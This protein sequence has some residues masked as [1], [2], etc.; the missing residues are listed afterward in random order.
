VFQSR[1]G[2]AE[3]V[4][5]VPT[6]GQSKAI[7]TDQSPFGI[8]CFPHFSPFRE[9]RRESSLCAG[10]PN[11]A[12][13]VV[14]GGGG[15]QSGLNSRVSSFHWLGGG[16]FFGVDVNNSFNIP[17]RQMRQVDHAWRC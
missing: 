8:F 12:H 16:D 10:D 3:G 15:R 5:G 2:C 14:E 6:P 7:R 13:I 4:H 11:L 9:G 1:G 17:N